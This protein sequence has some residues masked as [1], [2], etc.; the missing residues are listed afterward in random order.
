MSEFTINGLVYETINDQEL[1][2]MRTEGLK[3]PVRNIPAEVEYGGKK[4]KVTEVYGGHYTIYNE[5]AGAFQDDD[6]LTNL[7]LPE[8]IKTINR[9]SGDYCSILGA[10]MKCKKLKDIYFPNSLEFI[11]E[12]A[13]RGCSAIET[14]Y[15]GD[16]LK[17]IASRSFDDCA[18][19]KEIDFND[20]L[21]KIGSMAFVSCTSLKNVFF[22]ESLTLIG[23]NAF[24]GCKAMTEVNIPAS[25]KTIEGAAFQNSGVKVV[26]IYSENINIAEDAFPADAQVNFLDANSFPKRKRKLR[27]AKTI[28]APKA[29][30]VTEEPKK[31]EPK[32]APKPEPKPAPKSEP[33]PDPKPEPKPESK[34]APKPEPKPEEEPKKKSNGF[35]SKLMGVFRSEPKDEDKAATADNTPS[36]DMISLNLTAGTTVET[37]RKEFNDAF[38]A[39]LRLYNGN[40]KAE[41]TDTLGDLGLTA[42][43]TFECRSSLTVGSF[44]NR[45][46]QNHGL[47]VKVYTCD[48]W[49]A[50]LDGLTLKA[51]GQV[52]KNAVKA[53]MESMIAYQRSDE[54]PVTETPAAPSAEVK[55]SATHKDYTIVV[56]KDNKVV[57]GKGDDFFDNTKGALREIS[58]EVGFEYD[59]NW[60][61]QQ[62]GSKLVDFI[63]KK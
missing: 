57:V 42:A 35:L 56:M 21:E 39:Q 50:V 45:M 31:E 12:C 48:E 32:P 40:K 33:K 54:E 5:I 34:P 60:N 36:S 30:H 20:K 61:T 11:G 63:N 16:N 38:G 52:K 17:E 7:S 13:F 46:M 24:E 28:E 58:A 14:L 43:G 25:V 62:F 1:K 3:R 51:A 9:Y 59:P 23:K 2:L 18:A 53:D 29:A 4:Y 19:L 44:I 8:T 26:N 27:G 41:S 6:V 10:F 22:P 47:K 15:F 37:L 55:K 49:V